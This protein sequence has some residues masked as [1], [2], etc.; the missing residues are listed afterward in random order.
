MKQRHRVTK[1]ERHKKRYRFTKKDCQR[2]YQAA[3]AKCADDWQL[4]AW[5]HRLVRKYYRRQARGA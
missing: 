2:G 1:R 3:L 5:L 4:Y